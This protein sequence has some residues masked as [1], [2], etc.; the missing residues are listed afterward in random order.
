MTFSVGLSLPWVSKIHT[1]LRWQSLSN[2][3]G[4]PFYCNYVEELAIRSWFLHERR[5][6]FAAFARVL[7]PA[8]AVRLISSQAS[9]CRRVGT[10]KGY[11]SLSSEGKRNNEI[12]RDSSI[13]YVLVYDLT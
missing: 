1:L 8:I 13:T 2:R 11:F 10:K 9:S 7:I 3:A 4:S 12:L 5:T 6:S